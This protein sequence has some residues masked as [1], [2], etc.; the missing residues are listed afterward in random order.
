MRL[1]F[2]DLHNPIESTTDLIFCAPKLSAQCWMDEAN[3]DAATRA[4]GAMLRLVFDFEVA[5][6][7]Q[8]SA[9]FK[10]IMIRKRCC[11][12]R[13]G[14][15][16]SKMACDGARTPFCWMLALCS[17]VKFEVKPVLSSP[18]F[19]SKRT[20]MTTSKLLSFEH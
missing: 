18:C 11:E 3:V 13:A 10:S 4:F 14:V 1:I 15:G 17:T 5:T 6:R 8:V 16:V 19:S 2:K 7:E 9:G 12:G 20:L